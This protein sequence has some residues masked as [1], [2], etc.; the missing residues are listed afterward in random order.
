MVV[1]LS[2]NLKWTLSMPI[3]V[4]DI[5]WSGSATY[6]NHWH[7]VWTPN[8]QTWQSNPRLSLRLAIFSSRSLAWSNYL[9]S[10]VHK[11]RTKSKW[12]PLCVCSQRWQ[13]LGKNYQPPDC[14]SMITAM[15]V[16]IFILCL[17][18]VAYR[19]AVPRECQFSRVLCHISLQ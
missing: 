1:H 16:F 6:C 8:S 17:R 2:F 4:F 7:Q 15:L 14:L 10:D 19:A 18:L 5:I 12:D 9:A 13:F 11:L 3:I